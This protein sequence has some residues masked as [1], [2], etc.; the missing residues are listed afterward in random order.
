MELTFVSNWNNAIFWIYCGRVLLD[1]KAL[2]A[3]DGIIL[4]D[5]Q[6][7]NLV[8]KL[9]IDGLVPTNMSRFIS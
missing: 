1:R 8:F 6:E 9:D 2:Q 4:G 3:I 7:E 5:E